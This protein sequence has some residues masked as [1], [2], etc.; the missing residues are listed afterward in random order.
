MNNKGRG[1]TYIVDRRL[2]P[3][4]STW[5]P[6]FAVRDNFLAS[7]VHPNAQS[8]ENYLHNNKIVN[9]NAHLPVEDIVSFLQ[10][11]RVQRSP[12]PPFPG[13]WLC[14]CTDSLAPCL[15]LLHQRFPEY[16]RKS[17][18]VLRTAVDRGK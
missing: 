9:S 18:V 3:R 7:P 1:G 16:R 5:P 10:Q 6:N 12:P 11:V 2:V 17:L 8:A 15:P 4:I 14:L 13:L